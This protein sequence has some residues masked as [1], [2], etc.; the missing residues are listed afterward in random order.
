MSLTGRV[1]VLM[2]IRFSCKS[3]MVL[4]E[5]ISVGVFWVKCIP[6]I[7]QYY[8]IL[9]HCDCCRQLKIIIIVYIPY[10]IY[11]FKSARHCC[12][13][14]DLKLSLLSVAAGSG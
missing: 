8:W 12:P 3:P 14:S 6:L 10:Y 11:W 13:A 9:N 5:E 4:S 1:P 2:E 7:E